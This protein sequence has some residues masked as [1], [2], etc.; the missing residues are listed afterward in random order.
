MAGEEV[1]WQEEWWVCTEGWVNVLLEMPSLGIGLHGHD[2]LVRLCGRWSRDGLLVY[3][4]D[5]LKATLD[6]IL[7]GLDR[8]RL[9]KK[10]GGEAALEDLARHVCRE[11]L[12]HLE[13]PPLELR[14]EARVP[15]GWVELYCRGG[16]GP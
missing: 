11:A 13:K 12:R 4:I 3:D 1:R 9:S 6:E 15:N 14:V 10:L 16:A 7:G 8:S 2:V 5:S